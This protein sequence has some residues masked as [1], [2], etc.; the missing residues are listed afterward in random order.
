MIKKILQT[1]R[2]ALFDLDGTLLDSMPIWDRLC[3]DYL[4]QEGKHPEERLEADLAAMTLSQ[5]AQYVHRHYGL[6]HSP[7]AII[8]Q[9]E[10]M[11]LE[12]YKTTLPL[13]PAIPALVRE[14]YDAGLALG[15]VTS[16]FPTAC[17]GALKRHGLWPLFSTILYTDTVSQDKSLPNIWKVAA[18]QL[19]L[20]PEDCIVFE[21]AYHALQGVREAGMSFVAVY[22]DSCRDWE[23][24]YAQADFSIRYT[25]I[26]KRKITADPGK[27][28]LTQF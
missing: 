1:Y 23:S 24:M 11:V 25:G 7:E 15:V 4:L 28:P 13:K 21:D 27:N 22:D 26:E 8:D 6:P 18:N 16:C 14:L 5:A 2:G 17:E 19:G 9:W 3:R 12:A 20:A 10:E